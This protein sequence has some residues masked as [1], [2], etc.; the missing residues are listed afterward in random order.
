MERT[1]KDKTMPISENS[2]KNIRAERHLIRLSGNGP[3]R[4]VVEE[5]VDFKKPW[6]AKLLRVSVQL[7]WLIGEAK[8]FAD[9]SKQDGQV[10][11]IGIGD[12]CGPV[13][14]I[15]PPGMDVYD[16]DPVWLQVLLHLSFL[17]VCLLIPGELLIR[18]CLWAITS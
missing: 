3:I 15:G 17:V 12:D 2:G 18:V 10:P 1:R 4:F 9:S 16:D 6:W 13:L 7:S 8:M 11:H 5:G 14:V